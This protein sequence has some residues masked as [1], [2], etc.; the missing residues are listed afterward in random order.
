M[1]SLTTRS[2]MKSFTTRSAMKSLTTR[3]ATLAACAAL[4]VAAT[5]VQAA[6]DDT[7][8]PVRSSHFANK[9]DSS[10]KVTGNNN[11]F[12]GNDLHI[13][14]GNTSGTAHSI[15]QLQT[16]AP[17]YSQV[18]VNVYNCTGTAFNQAAAPT[19]NGEWFSE[20]AT[21]P[22]TIST[23]P[24]TSDGDECL[25]NGVSANWSA[26]ANDIYVNTYAPYTPQA[27]GAGIAF[28]GRA[29][30]LYSGGVWPGCD[31]EWTCAWIT[32]VQGAGTPQVEAV[33]NFIVVA[34]P[35]T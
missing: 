30:S 22:Y 31:T 4:L 8:D 3:S 1:K 15:T 16:S 18:T 28:Y 21:P 13:G 23:F 24:P 2:A 25:S 33:I 27:G 17:P 5:T 9:G 14:D 12:A 7:H 32:S 26:A 19:T 11:N 29:G 34:P 10:I 35:T 6:A 20:A